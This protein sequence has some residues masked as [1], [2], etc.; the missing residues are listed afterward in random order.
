MSNS[1]TTH[2]KNTTKK[3]WIS[4]FP[5][6]YKANFIGLL[7]TRKYANGITT[8]VSKKIVV[9]SNLKNKGLLKPRKIL[10]VLEKYQA[11]TKKTHVVTSKLINVVEIIFPLS[12]SLVKKRKKA[13]SIP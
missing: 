6:L 3:P 10:S 13:V 4:T 7:E 9:I 5:I 12:F 1:G 11:I 2:K 8:M